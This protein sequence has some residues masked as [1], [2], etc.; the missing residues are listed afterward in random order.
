MLWAF[1]SWPLSGCRTNRGSGGRGRVPHRTPCRRLAGDQSRSACG[2]R[3]RERGFS[4]FC[5]SPKPG[6]VSHSFVF[7]FLF[8]KE[9][10]IFLMIFL[11]FNSNGKIFPI[12]LKMVQNSPHHSVKVEDGIERKFR[13]CHPVGVVLFRLNF[14]RLFNELFNITSIMLSAF[15][16]AKAAP[17]AFAGPS[18][19]RFFLPFKP[20]TQKPF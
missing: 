9:I 7:N 16:E 11:A 10:K 5:F 2:I 19:S 15:P 3:C 12:R 8:V 14:Y 6:F 20:K 4:S 18:Q 17:R 1:P 13:G